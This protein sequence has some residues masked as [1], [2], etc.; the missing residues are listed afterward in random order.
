MT[1]QKRINYVPLK[2]NMSFRHHSFVYYGC[3]CAGSPLARGASGWV[4]TGC[5]IPA[6][7]HALRSV[8]DM[9]KGLKFL[10]APTLDTFHSCFS[11]NYYYITE[12]KI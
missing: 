3:R 12:A 7:P 10:M 1:A 2:D 6:I 5:V 11:K 8:K 9:H 4:Q